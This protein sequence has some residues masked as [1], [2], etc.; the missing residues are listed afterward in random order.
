MDKSSSI[1]AD[2]IILDSF[3][4]QLLPIYTQICFCFPI[5]DPQ[6]YPRVI[7][8]LE[9]ALEE[10]HL[11]FPW[12]AGRVVNEGATATSSG[13]FKIKTV[14]RAPRLVVKD[15]RDDSSLPS[16]E[17]LRLSRFP[18]N[19]LAE[20]IVAPRKTSISADDSLGPEV[21][22]VQATLIKGGLILTFLGQHQAMDGIGQDHIVRLFSKAC[23]NEAF[24]DEERSICNLTTTSNNTIPLLDA[25][26]ELPQTV[27]NYQIVNNETSFGRNSP[28][29]SWA[30]F[31]F[32][33][34]SL[35]ALKSTA[36]Q[37]CPPTSFIS[38]DDALSAFIWKSV[39]SARLARLSSTTPSTFARAVDVRQMLGISNMHPGFVQ[40]MTYNTS[41]FAD[42]LS[43]PL[44]VLAAS[45][46]SKVD[47][48]TSTV[49]HDTRALATLLARSSDR[50]RVSFAASLKSTS[51]VFFS[52]WVKMGG[53]GYDFGGELG[54]SEAVRRSRSHVT[55][56]LMY[57]MPRSR[58][59]EVG[60][61]VCLR[62]EDLQALREDGEWGRFA[63][64][65]G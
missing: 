62:E 34:A 57:L 30:Y 60:L 29:C 56:G 25:S 4:Q 61:V 10:L 19:A 64:Y 15:L 42:L 27:S 14:G 51:D 24:T 11:H 41:T 37:T 17:A 44:G 6:T 3:G 40:N 7:E 13:A 33:R 58:E 49:A 47:P 52:S 43:Q 48:K 53:Y 5:T 26:Y 12:L 54:R 9:T 45:L 23:R 28:P 18:I 2:G 65:V 16:M 36:A 46:R 35:E 63:E 38:T 20:D 50:S 31:S 22:L 39:T 55:E 1:Q 8:T 21:L 32:S 59:G